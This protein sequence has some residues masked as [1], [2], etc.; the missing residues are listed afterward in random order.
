MGAVGSLG[1]TQINFYES[2]LNHTPS[3]TIHS[4]PQV[5]PRLGAT[6]Y[7]IFKL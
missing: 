7:T 1:I 2:H 3:K 5:T 4:Y 6:F